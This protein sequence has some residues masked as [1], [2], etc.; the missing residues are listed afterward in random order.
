MDDEWQLENAI[1][2]DDDMVVGIDWD[3]NDSQRVYAGIDHGKV[4]CS[5]DS[6]DSWTKVPVELGAIAVVA[7]IAGVV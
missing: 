5:E 2:H 4:Y 1:G 6:G 7:L 3:P